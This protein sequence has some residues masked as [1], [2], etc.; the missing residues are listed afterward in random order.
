MKRS[1]GILLIVVILITPVLA[2]TN[3]SQLSLRYFSIISGDGIEI[4]TGASQDAD[5]INT[6]GKLGTLYQHELTG[7][8]NNNL[9]FDISVDIFYSEK[10]HELRTS[11]LTNNLNLG[12]LYRGSKTN[13]ILKFSNR[14]YDP[15]Q[16]NYLN[17][18]GLSNDTQQQSVFNTYMQ[19]D[20]DFGKVDLDIYTNLRDLEY[21]YLVYEVDNIRDE[22]DDEFETYS[23]SDYDL[24]SDLKLSMSIFENL[25]IFSRTQY[26]N[27]LN[28]TDLFDQINLGGGFQYHNT[29]DLFSS[30]K[31]EVYYYYDFSKF[32]NNELDHNLSMK[33]RYTRRFLNG[34][35]GFVSYINRS[36]YDTDTARIYRVS[37]MLRLHIMYS[38]FLTHQ[39][40]SSILLGVKYNAENEGTFGFL[41]QTQY[42]IKNIYSTAK[43]QYSPDNFTSYSIKLEFYL[44]PL[45]SIWIKDEYQDF[46]NLQRQNLLLV[47]STVIF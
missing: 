47:G 16:T 25:K 32:R 3:W 22:E 14:N 11:F 42:L 1:F 4:M 36:C 2:L 43:V 8:I 41:E 29:A 39:K 30:L 45:Q 18:P 44:N 5:K 33:I 12:L 40:N 10:S 9:T 31:S 23:A 46:F 21:K 20:H 24:Y 37:N 15:N 6:K 28:P 7:K 27:D 35:N 13:L 34:F 19:F 17:L 26:K 38:Y